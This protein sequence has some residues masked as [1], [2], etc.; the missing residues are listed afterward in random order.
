MAGVEEQRGECRR[1]AE[2]L[3]TTDKDEMVA[4]G[5]GGFVGDFEGRA[6]IRE[7]RR[8]AGTRLPRQADETVGG[9]GGEAIGQ[10]L[11]IG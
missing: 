4:T 1:F 9:P 3:D 11:L 7:D 6:A 2:F 8:A 5:M 10:I